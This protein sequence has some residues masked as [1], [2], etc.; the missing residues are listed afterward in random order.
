MSDIRLVL[1]QTRY[2]VLTLVRNPQSR[3]FTLALPVL[4]LFL[5]VSVLGSGDIRVDG[6]NVSQETYFVPHILAFGIIG[7]TMVN[8]LVTVVTQREMGILKRRR[9]TPV[10]AWVI[11][12]GRTVASTL[13]AFAIVAV[14]LLVGGL[15]YDV[16]LPRSTWLA[17]GVTV[18]L[19]SVV[20]CT[21]AYAIATF[22]RSAE[23]ALPVAQVVSLPVYFISGIF[24]PEDGIPDWILNVA[25]VLPMRPLA[26]SLFDAFDP[27]TS[28]AAFDWGSLGI[29]SAWGAAALVVASRRFGWSPRAA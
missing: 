23:A 5:F 29:M 16:T 3:A 4:F 25:E 27:Q 22:V 14:L 26:T 2:D 9:S 12:A 21:L 28:G 6:R 19:G 10:P 1:H 15:A 17:A 8:V 20:F 7:A 11:I 24:F 13:T 18:T